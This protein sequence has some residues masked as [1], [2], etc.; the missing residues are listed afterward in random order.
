M[1]HRADVLK[2]DLVERVASVSR[3]R[4]GEAA[5]A[6]EGFIRQY[7][8]N[9]APEDVL[10]TGIEALAG[11]VLSLYSF[12][13]DR[14]PATPKIRV[15]NPTIEEHGWISEHTVLELINDDMPFLVDSITS[16]LA[17]REIGLHVL[18]HP[19]IKVDRDAKGR[20]K[21][22]HAPG[23]ETSP[24]HFESVMH[25]QVDHLPDGP[26]RHA[27]EADLSR[28]LNDVR[29]SVEDWQ[30]MRERCRAL[31][32]S[33]SEPSPGLPDDEAKEARD[34][35]QWLHDDHFTFLGFRE[36]VFEGAGAVP[37]ISVDPGAGLGILRDPTRHVF[38]EQRALA[39]MPG[40]VRAFLARPHEILITKS[41]SPATVHRPVPMDLIGVKRMDAEGRV[42]GMAMIA[43]LFT[44]VAYT[45][46]PSQIPVLRRKMKRTVARAGF[47]PS[48]HDGKALINI[49]ETFPRDELFQVS[50]DQLFDTA[51]GILPLLERPRVALF[52]RPDEFGRSV[53]FLVFVP[54]DRYDTELRRTIT[55]LLEGATGGRVLTFYTQISDS[56]LARLHVI[57]TVPG[58]TLPELDIAALEASIAEA[59]R[60]W[61]DRLRDAL[62]QTH[63]EE[64]GIHLSRRYGQAFSVSY[65][66]RH[67]AH[68]GVADIDRIE[69]VI[70]GGRIGM[71]LYR[72]LGKPENSVHFKLFKADAAV[73]LSDV[74]PMLE[75]LGFKAINEM[76][77]T[78][79]PAGAD[80]VAIHD[81]SLETSDGGGV[82]IGVVRERLQD[83]FARIWDGV[84]EDDRFNLLVLRAGLDWREIWILRAYAKYLRQAAFTFSQS[85]VE[86]ALARNPAIARLTVDLFAAR[87]DP[88]LGDARPVRMAD[89]DKA[90]S[91]AL[92][93][94]VNADEDRILRRYRNLVQATLRTN[95]YQTGADGAR[96]PYLSLKLDSLVVEELPLP[97][98]MVEIFV[99]SARMEGVHL[100]GGKVARGGIRW[101]DRKEDF[102]TEILGLMKAQMVKNSVIVPVGSKGGFVVKRPP[103][104][105]EAWLAEGV[106]CYRILMRG[107]LDLT[108]NLAS[109]AIVPPT[110][111]VRHDGDDPYLVVAADKG[112]ATFSDIAN[113][114]SDEYG[115]WLSDAF[116]SGGSQ[117]YDHKTMAITA[118]GAWE[119]VK[120]HF[121]EIDIDTQ[122]QDFTVV[123]VGDMSGDVFGNGMLRSPHIRLL[124]AFNHMHVFIDPAP[125]PAPAFAERERLF[126]LPRSQW[127]DYDS[128]LIS[129]GGGVFRRDAKRIPISSEMARRFGIAEP[130][131]A[132]ND[133]IRILLT[134]EIDLLFFGGI[135]TYVKASG[136]SQAEAGDR[137]NDPVRVDG[138]ALRA[139]V[140]GEGA[141]LGMTQRGRIEYALA[142]GRINTDA[143]DNSGGVDCSDH[144]VNIKI[145]LNRVVA[146]GDLTLK[147]RNVLLAQMTDDV[148]HLVL[149]DNYLQTQA[150]S[151]AEAH[152]VENLDAHVRLMRFLE[153]TGRLNRAV[154]FL[155]D[156]ET[157][158]ER[159]Q[160]RRG[161]T[162]P[163][164]AILLAYTKI[165]LYDAILGSDLP[166]D[167]Q[168]GDDLVRYFPERLR[169]GFPAAIQAHQ[170]RREIIATQAANSMVNRVG[171]A[172]VLQVMERTGAAPADIARAYIVARDAFELR[173]LWGEI[174]ALDGKVAAGTQIAMLGEINRL[175]ERGTLWLLRYGAKPMEI[176]AALNELAPG[177]AEL[178]A[179]MIG[180]LP[181]ETALL[182]ASRAA[183]YQAK[184]V[185]APLAERVAAHIV[186]TSA[187]DVVRLTART[188]WPA[189]AI[190]RLYF[191]AGRRFGLGWLRGAADSLVGLTHWQKLAA[192]AVIDDLYSLQRDVVQLVAQAGTPDGEPEAT[193]MVWCDANDE[194]VDK[195]DQLLAELRTQGLLDLAM[196]IVAVRQLRTLTEVSGG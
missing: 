91:E 55:D 46:T 130:A 66:A 2:A 15:Y 90:L 59:A 143:I 136:E 7:F 187:A 61:S 148:A 186:L 32:A 25:L 93:A 42:V 168:L 161:L 171:I 128:K 9:V 84:V 192:A 41:A 182:V 28:I 48:S 64:R 139:K 63:G 160:A 190:T 111:I 117:G 86:D 62:I 113:G 22:L 38:D 79:R 114:I 1:A 50:E 138:R 141:N 14:K 153:R 124:A 145:L 180:M 188:G 166:D 177:I 77:H 150:I 69:E 101:S 76:P 144:E 45:R 104:E 134:A 103:T 176:G 125:D 169:E 172:F 115:F 4:T 120:R 97:R 126:R 87:F 96:K 85:Y 30:A 71:S 158:S 12:L 123:G 82:E 6:V 127:S 159:A 105:R 29:A 132:P 67:S 191:A 149:R 193:L 109:G 10:G 196:L 43:G 53:S 24:G 27:L 68:A 100:R 74:L 34:F 147:Q 54:R 170:L 185:P 142:G 140:L 162:R 151:L 178:R 57:V 56:P 133:L 95:Y 156:E 152:A 20:L 173:D 154:E 44:S 35:L 13:R 181:E 92:D 16:E 75:H 112:T 189:A 36:Y 135:G 40:D 118:R 122:S 72:P 18:I 195:V 121:R 5:G 165:W 116:A 167:P 94:V 39:A 194:P 157:L 31:V 8:A 183:D 155:P 80:E 88:S 60:S 11:S 108:D 146:E 129:A 184:G 174:E 70:A 106:E 78:A 163:E 26:Q 83:A 52:Q 17:R 58:G 65:R 51:L 119:S 110:G 23:D 179:G 37:R 137:A 131:L 3:G 164:L 49:L 81:F 102:R 107:M 73:V 99:H 98:P 33:L 175:V 21:A 47:R 89:A 19:V